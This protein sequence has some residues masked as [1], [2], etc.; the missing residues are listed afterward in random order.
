M[1]QIIKYTI[2]IIK[3]CNETN[4]KIYY[5]CNETNYQIYYTYN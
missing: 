4:C 2:H 5:T 3:R 1:K